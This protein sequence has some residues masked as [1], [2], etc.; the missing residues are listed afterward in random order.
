MFVV[1]GVF[2][3]SAAGVAQ[4]QAQPGWSPV[5]RLEKLAIME[6]G[7]PNARP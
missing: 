2:L 4:S 3:A 7:F 5:A 6:D 1:S